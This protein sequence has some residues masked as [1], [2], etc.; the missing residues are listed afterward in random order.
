MYKAW[1]SI[2]AAEQIHYAALL[3]ETN[4]AYGLHYYS[5]KL[6]NTPTDWGPAEAEIKVLSTENPDP[7]KILSLQ[8]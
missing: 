2:C 6:W 1:T 3:S 5:P 8:A 7:S 4:K